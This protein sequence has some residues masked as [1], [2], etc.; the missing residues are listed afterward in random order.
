[1][2]E[3]S[4]QVKAAETK[5]ALVGTE[6]D[7]DRFDREVEVTAVIVPMRE[8]GKFQRK[9]SDYIIKRAGFCAIELI[10]GDK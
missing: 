4:A 8:I 10:E 5:K 9:F 1:M 2:V 7:T 6:V 3:T